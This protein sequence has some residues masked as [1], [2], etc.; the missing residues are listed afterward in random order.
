[1]I[2]GAARRPRRHAEQKD[3]QKETCMAPGF[4]IVADV[5]EVRGRQVHLGGSD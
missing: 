5:P 2:P 1:M 3:E 4:S